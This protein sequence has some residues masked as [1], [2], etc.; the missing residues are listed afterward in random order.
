MKKILMLLMV[1]MLALALVACGGGDKP[2]ADQ[3]PE[4]QDVGDTD[5]SPDDEGES[6]ASAESGGYTQKQMEDKIVSYLSKISDISALTLAGGSEIEYTA[7]GQ[8][9]NDYD[10]WTIY[11]PELDN[12]GMY[13]A[14]N[15]QLTAAGFSYEEDMV[16]RHVWYMDAGGEHKGIMF[17]PDDDEFPDGYYILMMTHVPED[18]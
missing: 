10:L 16:G 7:A 9:L 15:S 12:D 4:Q 5:G 2:A 18:Y 6:D 17:W 11:D 8:A 1:L 14:M 3:Q 13:E